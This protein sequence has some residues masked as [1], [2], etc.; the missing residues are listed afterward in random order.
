MGFADGSLET[1]RF[2]TPTDVAVDG[3]GKLIVLDYSNF[4]SQGQKKLQETLLLC[5]KLSDTC[6]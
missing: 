6:N 1:A 5:N 2:H 3:D 4:R